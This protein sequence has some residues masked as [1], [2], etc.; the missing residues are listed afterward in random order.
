MA[1][2]I[3]LGILGLATAAADEPTP[4][5]TDAQ[6]GPPDAAQRVPLPDDP[7]G[8]PDIVAPRMDARP[9]PRRSVP[10]GRAESPPST[11]RGAGFRTT[12]AL[13]GV[14]ALIVLLAWGY[15]VA[16]T[17]GGGRWSLRVRHPGLIEVLSRAA[18]SPRQSLYLVRVG[19]RLVLLGATADAVRPLDVIQDPDLVAS[20]AGQAAR[21]RPGSHSAEFDR[22]LER[23]AVGYSATTGHALDELT[24]P[25]ERRLAGVRQT[26]ADAVQRLRSVAAGRE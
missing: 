3:V 13:G 18:L 4:P 24:M 10:A 21:Q 8:S 11:A 2:L 26:L 14:V 19:P 16:A 22:C 25:E 20:L 17:R 23:E 6:V 7:W 1:T 15:R 5:P 12:L 9:L